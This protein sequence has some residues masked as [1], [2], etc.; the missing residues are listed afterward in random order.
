[1]IEPRIL[2]TLSLASMPEQG[3]PRHLAAGS[4]LVVVGDF[5][6]VVA[7]DE[8]HLGCFRRG[9]DEPGW[10]VRMFPGGLPREA[11]ARKAAKPDLEALLYLSAAP[12]QANGALLA[13]P[14]GSTPHRRR[15]ALLEL[16]ARGAP[17]REVRQIDFSA[18][19]L[20]LETQVPALN[21]EGSV[22]VE[23]RWLLLHRGSGGQ[24]RSAIL[25]LPLEWLRAATTTEGSPEAPPL[26]SVH[27]ID[28]G[29]IDSVALTVT[30]AAALPEGRLLVSAVAEATQDSYADGA[31]VGACLAVLQPDGKVLARYDLEPVFKIEG[32][33]VDLHG[34]GIRVLM[35]TD[36]DDARSP[37]CLLEIDQPGWPHEPH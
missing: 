35:V 17:L 31:C 1:M 13:V 10:L 25:D 37:S 3:R 6:Y 24:P 16:D 2:R 12:A 19:Y 22:V 26:F 7:D 29:S 21:I 36:A 20:A 33:H 11:V 32:I 5:F 34:T 14:S 9:G 23:D 4:G 30:D 28:L 8:L 15:G 18:L 27:W